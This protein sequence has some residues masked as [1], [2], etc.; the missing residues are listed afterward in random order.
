MCRESTGDGKSG[1]IEVGGGEK[2]E[3]EK[4][5][6]GCVL[7]TDPHLSPADHLLFFLLMSV[8]AKHSNLRGVSE[9]AVDRHI[10]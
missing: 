6:K 5:R 3:R 7:I 1:R 4:R 10:D 8:S 2:S 9:K